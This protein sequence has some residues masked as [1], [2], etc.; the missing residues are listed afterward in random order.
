MWT[1]AVQEK[2][3][4]QCV[5]H[6]INEFLLAIGDQGFQEINSYHL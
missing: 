6:S 4:N 5:W 3:I 2:N 1:D